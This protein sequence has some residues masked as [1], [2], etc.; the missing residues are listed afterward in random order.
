MAAIDDLGYEATM[1]TR[2]SLIRVEVLFFHGCPNLELATSRARQAIEH[3]APEA[4]LHL[5]RLDDEADAVARGFLGSPTVRVDGRDVDGSAAART[6]FGFQ[7]RVYDVDG[8]LEGAPPV[9]WIEAALRGETI[10]GG[11]TAPAH[12]GC[13][14]PRG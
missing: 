14:K 9:D 5:V 6:D 7:C 4:E 11:E 13:C 1:G 3:A 10:A 2:D 12:D 8:R